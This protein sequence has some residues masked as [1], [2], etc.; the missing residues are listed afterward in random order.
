MGERHEVS[1]EDINKLEYCTRVIKE[2][3]RLLP[4]V[5]LTFRKIDRDYKVGGFV[6]PKGTT[7]VVSI[8]IGIAGRQELDFL[9]I[10]RACQ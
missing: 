9:E 2:T 5:P 3:L 10:P 1:F 4:P 8:S 7:A 6:V